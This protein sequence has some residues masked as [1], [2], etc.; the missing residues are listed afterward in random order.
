[1]NSPMQWTKR[2]ASHFGGIRNGMVMCWPKR[3]KDAGGLRDQYHHVIDITPTIYEAAGV[4]A[5]SMLNGV[6][7]KPLDGVSMAYTWDETD[8]DGR[9]LIQYAEMFGNRSIYQN[10]WMAS[11]TPL[12]FAW[13]PEPQ[14]LTP[15]SF[16][17]E[18]YNLDE[19]F[20]QAKNLAK[21]NPEK[22]RA[23]QD[24]WWAE[25]SKNQV[26]P[27]NFSAQATVEAVDQRPSLTRGRNRFEYYEG[28]IRI[29]EGT[30]PA[31]RNTSYRLTARIE[32]PEGGAEGVL[33]TQGGRFGGWALYLLDGKPA[34]CYKRSQQPEHGFEITGADPLAP[35]KHV[36]TLNFDYDYGDGGVGRGGEFTL[37]VDGKSVA[38]GKVDRTI[39]YVIS[40]DETLDI[41]EDCGTPIDDAYADRM[42]FHFTGELERLII[43]LEPDRLSR[44]GKL[45]LARGMSDVYG[46]TE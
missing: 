32:V 3:I 12:A 13:L 8:A 46:A 14:G 5:P 36:V 23:L 28:T 27:L 33:A 15:E 10:G 31:L 45:K 40:V 7:Q 35:G 20:S 22:L 26:L 41:G 11:T 44:V 34:W 29:P 6:A 17:W 19:D 16:E 1:M 18:L 39:P 24:L 21:E 43:E 2:Y 25:A 42:P 9:R 30:A 38:G 4:T 37:S